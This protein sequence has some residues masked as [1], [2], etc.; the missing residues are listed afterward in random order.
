MC[1]VRH[2]DQSFKHDRRHHAF[3]LSNPDSVPG[4][5]LLQ[6]AVNIQFDFMGICL[7]AFCLDRQ[8]HHAVFDLGDPFKCRTFHDQAVLRTDS[9]QLALQQFTDQVDRV[10]GP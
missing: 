9:R 6:F 1:G 5:Q 8:C 10:V 7:P 2:F 4:E 3:S